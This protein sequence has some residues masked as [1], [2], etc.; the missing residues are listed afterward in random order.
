[1]CHVAGLPNGESSY[2]ETLYPDCGWA[3]RTVRMA[4]ENLTWVN[5][6]GLVSECDYQKGIHLQTVNGSGPVLLETV[7]VVP[8][9]V[10][11]GS[12]EYRRPTVDG[13]VCP[14]PPVHFHD[15]STKILELVDAWH[16]EHPNGYPATCKMPDASKTP[17]CADRPQYCKQPM[18]TA[19]VTLRHT[20]RSP[21]RRARNKSAAA[22]PA[23]HATP[24]PTHPLAM[25]RHLQP[26]RF[27]AVRPCVAPRSKSG[28]S[29]SSRSC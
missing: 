11:Y 2:N 23:C 8:S 4:F 15:H 13:S 24:S 7:G 16:A 12:Y 20:K 26:T 25:P 19:E 10:L 1:M 22:P 14:M 6:T 9:D 18:I 17:W 28:R 27:A 21:T 5:H 3:M 29:R